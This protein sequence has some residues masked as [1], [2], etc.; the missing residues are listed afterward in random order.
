MIVFIL[1]IN[2]IEVAT[3]VFYA[4]DTFC[5]FFKLKSSGYN[6]KWIRK[7]LTDI[8][9]SCLHLIMCMAVGS[10]WIVVD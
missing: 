2:T 5:L 9:L 6:D 3:E 7:I 1:Y 8:L 10:W 4:L